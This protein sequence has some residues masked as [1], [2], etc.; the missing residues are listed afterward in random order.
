M[1]RTGLSVP[2]VVSRCTTANIRASGWSRSALRAWSTVMA[3]PGGSLTS[4]AAAP[5]TRTRSVSTW[6]NMP[7]FTVTHRSPGSRKV[8]NAASSP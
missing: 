2:A 5:T 8:L 3:L 7:V 6:P 4:A 1:S